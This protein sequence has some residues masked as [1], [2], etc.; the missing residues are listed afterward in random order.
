MKYTYFPGCSLEATSRPY[1]L[2]CQGVFRALGI[3]LCELKDWNC[4][5]ATAYMAIK[6]ITA[7]ALSARNLALAEEEERD[8]VTP[9]SG[10]YVVLRKTNAS[11]K[12]S[13]HL[14]DIVGD[15]LA[16]GG[17][18]YRGTVRARHVLDVLVNDVGLDAISANVT[19]PL[20]GL[21]V[22]AYYGCQVVRPENGFDHPEFPTSLDR[23]LEALGATPVNYPVKTRCCGGSLTGTRE[24]LGLRMTK[25]ILLCAAQNDAQCLVT[26]CPLC[27]INLD[28]FQPRINRLFQKK[29][30]MPVLHFTQVM[31]LALGLGVKEMGLNK[32]IVPLGPAI[33]RFIREAKGGG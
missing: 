20:E 3:E 13:S 17:L 10:C 14:N 15:A 26:C 32:T 18:R 27:H 21:K 5:G 12:E 1:D 28:A 31:G 6:E 7:L 29:I 8:L 33:Y 23:L 22:A 9:C 11:L 25:N 2:S 16:A 30:N 19:R 24:E 4:C